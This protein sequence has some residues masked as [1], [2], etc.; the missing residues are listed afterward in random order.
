MLLSVGECTGEIPAGCQPDGRRA[1]H[2]EVHVGSVLV[3]SPE[4]LQIPLH[5]I[6]SPQSGAASQ[7]GGPERKGE[8]TLK[9]QRINNC[10]KIMIS[11]QSNLYVN[12]VSAMFALLVR[13]YEIKFSQYLP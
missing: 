7:R 1:T 13:L 4:V 8:T 5:R 9:M 10:I 3:G 6:Q 12:V 11:V 2:E